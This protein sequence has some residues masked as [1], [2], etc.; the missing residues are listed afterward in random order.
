L[1]AFLLQ[2]TRGP[3]EP[4]DEFFIVRDWADFITVYAAATSPSAH[5]S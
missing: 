3:V 2:P 5:A 1:T 4:S